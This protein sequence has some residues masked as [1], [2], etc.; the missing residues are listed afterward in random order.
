MAMTALL[1][2]AAL[3]TSTV[4]GVVG[5]AGG[6]MLLGVMVVLGIDPILTVPIHAAVQ[7]VSNI[8]RTVAHI[9]HVRWRPFAVQLVAALPG[10]ILGL[11]LLEGLDRDTVRTVMGLVI[12]YTVWAPRWGLQKIPD[13][14]AFSLAGAIAGTLGVVVG[15]VGPLI[16]PF[17]LRPGFTKRG[18]IS[19]KAACQASHHIIKLAA[20]SGLYPAVLASHPEIFDLRDQLPLI[21]PMAAATIGGAYI[22]RWLLTRISDAK[23]VVLYKVVLTLLAVRMITQGML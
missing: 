10:P 18:I 16:A 14:A 8:A 9:E 23:F 12:L 7:L 5:M 2:L 13:A 22:G 21:L 19:T 15:A 3:A 1:V 17:F 4:S 6:A 11:W 20:F